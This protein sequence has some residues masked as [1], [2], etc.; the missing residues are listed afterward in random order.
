MMHNSWER[1]VHKNLNQNMAKDEQKIRYL[2]SASFFVVSIVMFGLFLGLYL[3]R[4]CMFS[5]CVPLNIGIAQFIQAKMNLC[6]MYAAIGTHQDGSRH[7]EVVTMCPYVNK[8][9]RQRARRIVYVSNLFTILGTLVAFSV[10]YAI[11]AAV[12]MTLYD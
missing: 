9:V 1:F 12:G 5:L 2:V 11:E 6:V 10:T 8:S 3:P 7:A 4:W